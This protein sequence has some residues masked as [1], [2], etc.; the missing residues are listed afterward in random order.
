MGMNIFIISGVSKGLGYALVE[1]ILSYELNNLKVIGLSRN[2]PDFEI[3]YPNKFEWIN[4][5]F[6]NPEKVLSLIE[7]KLKIYNPTTVCF[8]N[9]A[10][11]IN[12]IAKIGTIEDQKLFDSV[13]I[14]ILSPVICINYLLD[15]SSKL[16]KLILVNITSGAANKAINGWSLYCSA[17]SY[18]KMYFDVLF[19]EMS[20]D[21]RS[22]ILVKQIDPGAMNTEMQSEI[23][24]SGIE[25]DQYRRLKTMHENENLKQPKDVADIIIKDIFSE[26]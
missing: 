21:Q 5:D 6:K 7:L 25:S 12:P 14:N 19:S 23:R 8:I 10:G 22:R 11:D 18:M 16:S 3:R 15:Y 4:A 26:I 2:V 1:K 20:T 24:N 9:N 13:S 17:K